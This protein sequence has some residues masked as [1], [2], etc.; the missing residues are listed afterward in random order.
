M[1]RSSRPS[2]LVSLVLGLGLLLGTC[3]A[4]SAPTTGQGP[5]PPSPKP[6][7]P[8]VSSPAASPSAKASPGTVAASP[9]PGQPS[10]G[11]V[12]PSPGEPSP[13]AVQPGSGSEQPAPGASPTGEANYP[14]GS[15]Q[16][17]G[18]LAAV[19]PA[20]KTMVLT[21]PAIPEQGLQ[22]IK[23][24]LRLANAEV[25]KGC[26]V[27]DVVE[28]NLEGD[29]VKSMTVLPGGKPG[30]PASPGLASP[31]NPTPRADAPGG[32]SPK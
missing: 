32:P 5:E 3:T 14:A 2:P 21:V 24:T 16:A 4:C 13:G 30:A 25:A 29:L 15:W 1:F 27:G 7:S 17:Q 26:K 10:P 22:E 28:L 12:Q 9:A 23:N 18:V 19:D 20:N 6:P 31:P 8:A 11:A